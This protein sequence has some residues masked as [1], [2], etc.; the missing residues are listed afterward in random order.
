MD[1]EWKS[2]RSFP[3]DP[4]VVGK[5]VDR[6]VKKQGTCAPSSLVDTARKEAS[7]LHPLFEWRDDVAAEKHRVSQARIVLSSLR[8]V[9]IEGDTRKQ[10]PAFLS[11]NVRHT[12][13]DAETP[14]DSGHYA[15][16]REVRR[17][18]DMRATAVNREWAQ[19]KGWLERTAWIEEFAALRDAMPIVEAALKTPLVFP[20]K[21]A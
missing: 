6:I 14:D 16:I 1:Y 19:I 10:P 17:D 15:P 7:P 11:V 18:L 13:T 3:V 8:V 4:S 12:A 20:D 5:A 9:V 21:A 2:G